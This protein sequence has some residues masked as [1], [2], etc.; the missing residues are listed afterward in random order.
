[1]RFFHWLADELRLLL[2]A[3]LYFSACCVLIMILKQFL[4]AQYGIALSGITT[5][6]VVALVTAKVLI[7]LQKVPL[8]GWFEDQPAIVE[9]IARTALYTVAAMVELQTPSG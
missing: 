9:V 8:G 4:L 2:A 1:M 5:A 7:V 3:T 6:V